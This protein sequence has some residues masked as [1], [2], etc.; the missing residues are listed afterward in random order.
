M[1]YEYVFCKFRLFHVLTPYR[2]W[3]FDG[4][5]GEAKPL[6]YKVFITAT[7]VLLRPGMFGIKS[8]KHKVSVTSVAV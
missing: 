6:R 3:K 2:G 5:N 4:I 1:S 7:F 8:F